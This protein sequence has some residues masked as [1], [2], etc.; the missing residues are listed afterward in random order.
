M[1][2][3]SFLGGLPA[4]SFGALLENSFTQPVRSPN[5]SKTGASMAGQDSFESS[6]VEVSGNT[7]FVRRYGSGVAIP[8]AQAGGEPHRDLRGSARLRSQRNTRIYG[9]SLSLFQARHGEGTGGGDGQARISDLH[10]DWPRPRRTR[11]LPAGVGPS[12]ER[13]ATRCVRR[14]SHPRSMEPI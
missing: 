3:R 1:E 11:F 14:D 5:S 6:K 4:T 13:G 10:A 9:R 2:R 8:L 7:I 12:Q